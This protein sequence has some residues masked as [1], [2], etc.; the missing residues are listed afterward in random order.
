MEKGR[1]ILDTGV[2]FMT[3]MLDLFT[4]HGQF[5]LTVDANGDTDIDDH[6]TTEDIGIC[7]RSCFERSSRG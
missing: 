2:P 1:H 5:D 7:L 6:H 4:K 3:H